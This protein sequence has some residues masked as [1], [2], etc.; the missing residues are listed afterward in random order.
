M[1]KKKKV[2]ITVIIIAVLA[3]I[4][5]C[6]FIFANINQGKNTSL[7]GT[8]QDKSESNTYWSIS[9]NKLIKETVDQ[10]TIKTVT[11]S[12]EI[13]EEEKT[14]SNINDGSVTETYSYSLED[15]GKSVKIT[16]ISTA[17]NHEDNA[18][19]NG[20]EDTTIEL[21]RSD[22]LKESNIPILSS[23][24]KDNALVGTWVNEEIGFVYIFDNN[25]YVTTQSG[26][27][28]NA[29]FKCA[30]AYDGSNLIVKN[31]SDAES[32]I[33]IE[34]GGSLMKINDTVFTKKGE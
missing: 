33:N 15:N 17:V 28:G 14:F 34:V 30:Y 12:I 1:V 32:K 22:S 16:E 11:Y 10:Y 26:T 4:V 29:E 24:K 6:V 31:S 20:K 23:F 7:I 3:L 5:G 21:Q 19:K 2:L 13:N 8:W 25:G 9:N 27:D 18:E